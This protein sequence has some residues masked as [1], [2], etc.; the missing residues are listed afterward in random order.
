MWGLLELT[1]DIWICWS[2]ICIKINIFWGFM[3]KCLALATLWGDQDSVER[4]SCFSNFKGVFKERIHQWFFLMNTALNYSVVFFGSVDERIVYKRF[5]LGGLFG[6][7]S[8]A[9]RGLPDYFRH[10]SVIKNRF[11]FNRFY[12]IMKYPQMSLLLSSKF[13][14]KKTS[15]DFSSRNLPSIPWQAASGHFVTK[16]FF[17]R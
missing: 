9:Q 12:C 3:K 8:T 6:E 11:A 17:E 13:P 1:S 16:L 7:W 5:F 4:N 10:I 14:K 15:T 2:L